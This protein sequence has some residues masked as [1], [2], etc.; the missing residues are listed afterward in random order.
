[1]TQMSNP[2][3]GILVAALFTALIQSS[4]ATTGVII[5]LAMQGLISLKAGIALSFGANIGT[6]VT[7]F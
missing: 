3:W 5:V 1:M 4:S 6:C 7:A 2:V